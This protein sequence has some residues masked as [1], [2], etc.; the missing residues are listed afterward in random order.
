[1][2]QLL[3]EN[4]SLINKIKE[5]YD[6]LL[7][8]NKLLKENI[9][10]LEGIKNPVI[11]QAR[12]F[13]GGYNPENIKQCDKNSVDNC[14]YCEKH[15][16]E[17]PYGNIK[18][19]NTIGWKGHSQPHS[20]SFIKRMDG[21][22]EYNLIKIKDNVT[23]KI[24][25]EIIYKFGDGP[26]RYCENG[27]YYH[28]VG[29]NESSWNTNNKFDKCFFVYHSGRKKLP[30][31]DLDTYEPNSF[32]CNCSYNDELSNNGSKNKTYSCLGHKIL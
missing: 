32:C 7:K 18:V 22:F 15:L 10:A 3:L 5:E 11:C 30:R 21:W 17:L 4:Y 1:M 26:I 29:I 9:L 24:P 19:Y 27:I 25:E 8:E 13:S 12:V 28:G 2:D 14:I 23:G 16:Q 20:Q 6:I 31:K